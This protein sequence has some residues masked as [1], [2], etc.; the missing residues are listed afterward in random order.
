MTFINAQITTHSGLPAPDCTSNPPKQPP[1]G[2]LLIAFTH[3]RCLVTYDGGI[4]ANG[5]KTSSF[6]H[7]L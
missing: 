3:L 1:I 7:H 6:F 2:I 4:D 5:G